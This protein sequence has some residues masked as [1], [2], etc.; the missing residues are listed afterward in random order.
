LR[1]C[2]SGHIIEKEFDGQDY[3]LR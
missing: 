3:D 1:A 2:K